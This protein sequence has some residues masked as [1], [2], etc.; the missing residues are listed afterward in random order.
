MAKFIDNLGKFIRFRQ[1]CLNC[2][3]QKVLIVIIFSLLPFSFVVVI[4]IQ[5]ISNRT[6]YSIHNVNGSDSLVRILEC[7]ESI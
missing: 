7:D 4:K 2:Y 6:V 5:E 1:L 3:D